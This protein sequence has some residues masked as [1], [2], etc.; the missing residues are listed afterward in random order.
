MD[1]LLKFIIAFFVTMVVFA[2]IISNAVIK[3]EVISCVK[4]ADTKEKIEE[5]RK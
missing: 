5:C 2:M 4:F 3:S 1:D